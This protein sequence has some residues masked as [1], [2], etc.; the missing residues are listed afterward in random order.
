M[1]KM[2]NAKGVNDNARCASA[3]SYYTARDHPEPDSKDEYNLVGII[4]NSP[5]LSNEDD[6]SIYFYFD[7]EDWTHNHEK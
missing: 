2:V 7:G 1:R 5:F 6:K 4:C 3:S